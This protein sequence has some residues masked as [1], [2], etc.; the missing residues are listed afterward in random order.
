MDRCRAVLVNWIAYYNWIV[1]VFGHDSG[2]SYGLSYE[3][4]Q[5]V[6]RI[7]AIARDVFFI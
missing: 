1:S 3:G 6:I 2:N 7:I 4:V 5:V